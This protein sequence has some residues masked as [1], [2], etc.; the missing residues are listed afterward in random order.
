LDLGQNIN[1][2]IDHAR[3]LFTDFGRLV[4]LIILHII[5]IV[6]LIVIGYYARNIRETPT[7]DS[8]PKLEKYADL[9][10]NGLKV[11]VAAII[12]M[13]VPIIL[14]IIGALTLFAPL[15]LG[16]YRPGMWF[17]PAGFGGILL[18]SGIIIAF[19]V[20]IIMAMAIVHMIKSDSFGK[21][22]AVGEIIGMIGRIGW[23]RYILWL[24]VMFIF[25]IIVG[26]INSIPAIGWLISLI[27]A[28]IYGVFTSRSAALM[29]LDGVS[30]GAAPAAAVPAGKKFCMA[31]GA[32]IPSEATFCPICGK[33]Q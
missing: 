12:Y 5:P 9:W 11:A 2:S 14:I 16:M 33:P 4:I 31:C 19:A 6:N 8:P 15:M 29:Y 3:K 32:S 7:S 10:I 17:I 25:G 24:I 21:A 18:A 28:P 1:A 30:P 23:G 13:I 22:F 26:A 27:I 20:A